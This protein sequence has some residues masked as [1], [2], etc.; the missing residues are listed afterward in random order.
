MINQKVVIDLDDDGLAP[1]GNNTLSKPIVAP[2]SNAY[3]RHEQGNGNGYIG[4]T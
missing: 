1:K 4:L 3:S 2:I